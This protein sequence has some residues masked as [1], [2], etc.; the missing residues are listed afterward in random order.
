MDLVANGGYSYLNALLNKVSVNLQ[1]SM[2][3]ELPDKL[4]EVFGGLM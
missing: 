3:P 2:N 4:K 1:C